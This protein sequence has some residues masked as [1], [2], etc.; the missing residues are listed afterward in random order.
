M[1]IAILTLL[2]IIFYGVKAYRD[3]GFIRAMESTTVTNPVLYKKNIGV[4]H[5]ADIF[6][7]AIVHVVMIVAVY[8]GITVKGLCFAF[9]YLGVS[10]W[11][12]NDFF[13]DFFR[14]RDFDALPSVD[15]N[16]DITDWTI[17][18]LERLHI[19]PV[20]VKLLLC[21]ITGYIFYGYSHV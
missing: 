7:K 17:V 1:T 5:V 3:V 20:V 18:Q 15:G 10:R 4:W 11:L 13:I 14:G 9:V 21:G 8:P 19:P 16:W 6:E 2:V 12:W